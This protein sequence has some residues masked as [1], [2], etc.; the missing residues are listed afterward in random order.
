MPCAR[1][2][3][4]SPPLSRPDRTHRGQPR[5]L[6]RSLRC[7][8]SSVGVPSSL[9]VWRRFARPDRQR[10]GVTGL[11]DVRRHRWRSQDGQRP[12][13]V[14]P[15][16]R[17]RGGRQWRCA[18]APAR[19]QPIE[20]ASVVAEHQVDVVADALGDQVE[21]GGLERPLRAG[22]GQVGAEHQGVRVHRVDAAQG[23]GHV[24]VAA[25]ES[26]GFHPRPAVDEVEQVGQPV[27]GHAEVVDADRGQLRDHRLERG[28]HRPVDVEL[29]MPADEVV[30]TARLGDQ[31]LDVDRAAGQIEPQ[32]PHAPPVQAGDVAVAGVLVEL[33]DA[34]PSRIRVRPGRRRDSVWSEPW[35]EPLTTAP[36]VTSRPAMRAR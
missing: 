31:Q 6:R 12:G 2:H 25:T 18:L 3:C 19:P 27:A 24:E 22:A 34:H 4:G 5:P 33:G 15:G 17:R 9:R 14:G 10:F 21:V 29:G 35:K 1:R 13:R 28:E 20:H 8:R 16:L 30:G 36:P 26:A 32:A 11:R 23:G 7:S